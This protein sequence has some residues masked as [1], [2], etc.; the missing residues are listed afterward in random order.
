MLLDLKVWQRARTTLRPLLAF[1]DLPKA[2]PPP[3]PTSDAHPRR[4]PPLP[5]GRGKL[6]DGTSTATAGNSRPSGFP[7]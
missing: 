2:L 5:Q 4:E 6:S 7:L 1:A 3:L